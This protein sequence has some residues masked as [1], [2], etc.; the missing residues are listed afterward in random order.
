MPV[1]RVD[2]SLDLQDAPRSTLRAAEPWQLQQE[3]QMAERANERAKLKKQAERQR[4]REAR[5]MGVPAYKPNYVGRRQGMRPMDAWKLASTVELGKVDSEHIG[6]IG[7]RVCLRVKVES[8]SR[9]EPTAAPS[10]NG[11]EDGGVAQASTDEAGLEADVAGQGSVSSSRWVITMVTEDGDRVIY[12]VGEDATRARVG[13]EYLLEAD[14]VAHTYDTVNRAQ[15]LVAEAQLVPMVGK[16]V[17]R[18]TLRQ[19]SELGP[20]FAATAVADVSRRPSS[21]SRT[22]IGVSTSLLSTTQVSHP[23]GR[24]TAPRNATRAGIGVSRVERSQHSKRQEGSKYE[25]VRPELSDRTLSSLLEILRERGEDESVISTILEDRRPQ[26]AAAKRASILVDSSPSSIRQSWSAATVRDRAQLKRPSSAGAVV[27]GGLVTSGPSGLAN[28]ETCMQLLR[29][30]SRRPQSAQAPTTPAAPADAS[31]QMIRRH[32]MTASSLNRSNTG[33]GVS[34]SMNVGSAQVTT[35][36][37]S[38][39]SM[40]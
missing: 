33:L 36:M 23:W 22:R 17:A 5:R 24:G 3:R 38:G 1:D 16:C 20:V 11:G 13:V 12:H 37:F 27:G 18:G 14:I 39:S 15:T 28:E 32:S 4:R 8:N 21:A 31:R 35:R 10:S 2:S 6:T 7:E 34:Y 25:A 30:A 26:L 19:W 29:V 9:P 40:A